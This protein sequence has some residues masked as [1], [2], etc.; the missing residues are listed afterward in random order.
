VRVVVVHV[1]RVLV[2]VLDSIVAVR[3]GVLSDGGRIVMMM[4]VRVVVR[5]DVIVLD[6]LVHVPV[7]VALGGVEVDTD[8]EQRDGADRPCSRVTIA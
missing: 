7:R 3:V 1:G 4:V 8:P 2:I 6:W 5:V